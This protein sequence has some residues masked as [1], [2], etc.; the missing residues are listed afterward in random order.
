[1]SA[2]RVH[3]APQSLPQRCMIEILKRPVRCS[4]A[5]LLQDAELQKPHLCRRVASILLAVQ[6]FGPA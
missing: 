4:N 6:L 2:C 5:E 3:E 1:M